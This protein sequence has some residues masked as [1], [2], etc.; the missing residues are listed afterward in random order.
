[1]AS[2]GGAGGAG[3]TGYRTAGRRGRRSDTRPG[4]AVYAPVGRRHAA[5]AV[6]VRGTTITGQ[7]ARWIRR[8]LTPRASTARRGW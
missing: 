1:M 7:L 8:P 6:A 4:G 3:G 2:V 5:Y